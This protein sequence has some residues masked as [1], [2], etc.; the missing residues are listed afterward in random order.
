[1]QRIGLA[2]LAAAW[3]AA[4]ANAQAPA[5]RFQWTNGQVQH[6][7]VKKATTV[8][9]TTRAEKDMKLVTTE[10][11]EALD[12]TKSWTVRDVD[13]AG[14]ATL[15]LAITRMRQEIRRADGKSTLMDSANPAD[16]RQMDEYLNKPVL[17]IRVDALGQ[18][19]DVKE[20]K[21]GTAGRIRTE[22]PFRVVL[23]AAGPKPGQ[24][25]T[26]EFAIRL[27]PPAGT[28]ETYDA[29]QTCTAKG[30]TDG[31]AVIGLETALK[32]PPKT[33][34]ERLPLVPLLWSGDVFIDAAAGRFHAARLSAKAEIPDFEGEGTKF[35]YESTYA[36]D[37]VEK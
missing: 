16:A 8:T 20:T 11:R 1:M 4:A 25:W 17:T 5:L 13:A 24:A 7:R 18:V 12:L 10:V 30:V 35:A 14:T 23:P 32:A 22:L 31:L 3:V 26:R 36:E 37:A 15:E 21:P 19:L 34:S 9:E 2:F 28:G 6:Y 29:V 33:A 27:D